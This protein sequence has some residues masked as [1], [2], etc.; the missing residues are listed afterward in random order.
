MPL[1]RI[2][3]EVLDGLPASMHIVIETRHLA[4]MDNV[5]VEYQAPGKFRSTTKRRPIFDD[6]VAYAIDGFAAAGA[7]LP[8][9]LD[10]SGIL[11][12]VYPKEG[13]VAVVFLRSIAGKEHFV[14][15]DYDLPPPVMQALLATTGK[16][17]REH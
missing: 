7:M 6:A 14:V 9:L 4:A 10:E 1:D 3:G 16:K 2:N 8:V 17:H 11:V 12:Q 5:L 13:K 15:R